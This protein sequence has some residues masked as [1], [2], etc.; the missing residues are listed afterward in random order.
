MSRKR[1]KYSEFTKDIISILEK[2]DG[3]TT[4]RLWNE[5]KDKTNKYLPYT[6]F[7]QKL[8]KMRKDNLL[9]VVNHYIDGNRYFL[10]LD[11]V[12]LSPNEVIIR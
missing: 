9:F 1:I 3:L 10:T 12:E 11:N 7:R 5:W 6:P 8:G 2:S 4:N